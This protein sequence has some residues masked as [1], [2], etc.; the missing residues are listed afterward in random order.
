MRLQWEIKPILPIWPCSLNYSLMIIL[1]PL[2]VLTD[3]ENM[4]KE[5]KFMVL[6]C[7]DHELWPYFI[8]P[9]M[10]IRPYLDITQRAITFEPYIV[11]Y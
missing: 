9:Y 3:H 5:P 6:R 4:G 8:C 7:T 11:E 10:D 2:I 1:G